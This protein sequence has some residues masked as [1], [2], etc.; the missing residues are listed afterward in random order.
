MVIQIVNL[1]VKL[2]NLDTFLV[3]VCANAR[4]SLKE[5]GVIRF[6]VL[7]QYDLPERFLLYEVYDCP[8]SLEAHRQTAHFKRWLEVGVPLLADP[9]EKVLYTPVFSENKM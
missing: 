2:T 9:R 8:E 3:E 5:S 6:D 1:N 7:Q 4:E